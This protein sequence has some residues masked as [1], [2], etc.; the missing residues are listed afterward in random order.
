MD[1]QTRIR[2]LRRRGLSVGRLRHWLIYKPLAVLLVIL[3]LPTLPWIGG[4]SGPYQA[5]AQVQGC[6]ATG[7]SIIQNYCVDGVAYFAD[8]FQ[9]EQESVS[10]YLALHRIPQTDANVIYDYGRSD[11]RNAVRGVMVSQLQAIFAMP[12]SARDRHQ[13]S[14]Y[15]WMQG[16]V[17]D[18]EVNM[19]LIA[20][21]T[22]RSW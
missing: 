18:N 17:H 14:L 20:L 10:A 11:L 2:Q 1:T 15:N 6:T 22:F 5:S 7:N 8:L 3:L 21:N 13:Q 9:L 16:L 19:H 4:A 12:A